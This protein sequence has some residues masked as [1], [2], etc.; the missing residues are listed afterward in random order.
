MNDY[1]RQGNNTK[2]RKKGRFKEKIRK[3]IIQY[4]LTQME[5]YAK[6]IIHFRKIK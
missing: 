2:D 3:N 5:D 1:P 6:L 4:F